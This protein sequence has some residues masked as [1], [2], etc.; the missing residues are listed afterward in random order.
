MES[1]Q[2][3]GNNLE[4]WFSFLKLEISLFEYGV[5]PPANCWQSKWY[6]TLAFEIASFYPLLLLV[7]KGKSWLCLTKAGS[8]MITV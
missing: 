4:N 3:Y 2:D 5:L 1:I 7:L 6:Q 8:K